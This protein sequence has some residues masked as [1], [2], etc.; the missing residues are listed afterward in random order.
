MVEILSHDSLFSGKC[1]ID[2]LKKDRFKGIKNIKV[3]TDN[4][5]HFRSC[6]I[7]DNL[8]K[9]VQKIIKGKVKFN[10][11]LEFHGK[12]IVDEH[13]GVLSVRALEKEDLY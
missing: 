2:L 9:M 4:V 8:F 6:D 12:I 5:N 1:L 7:L 13:F 10:R 11:F 3:W